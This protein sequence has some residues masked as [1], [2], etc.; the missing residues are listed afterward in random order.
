MNHRTD[1]GCAKMHGALTRAGY[2]EVLRRPAPVAAPTGQLAVP[3][4][5]SIGPA[6]TST[7]LAAAPID[8]A[9]R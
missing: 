3:T 9:P 8:R 4:P 6:P 5:T 7:T 2:Q 1:T